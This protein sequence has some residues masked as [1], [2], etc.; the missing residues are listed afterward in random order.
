MRIA[1]ILSLMLLSFGASAQS[2]KVDLGFNQ[3]DFSLKTGAMLGKISSDDNKA[4]GTQDL[5]GIIF[6]GIFNFDQTA[7]WTLFVSPEAAFDAGNMS[8]IRK[9]AQAGFIYHILGGSKKV[10]TPLYNATIV[11]SYPT[12][13]GIVGKT[14]Y[15]DYSVIDPQKLLPATRGTVTEN[16][17]GLDFRFD[18]ASGSSIGGQLSALIVAIPSGTEN[19]K[20][21]SL[22]E[23][24]TYWR[25]AF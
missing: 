6:G 19:L 12:S 5:G 22:M 10:I 3:F 7:N 2:I 9:G 11:T 25:W 20:T 4:V 1:L 24:F 14:G 23:I 17:L 21:S 18:M 15:F 16:S 8:A 13:L